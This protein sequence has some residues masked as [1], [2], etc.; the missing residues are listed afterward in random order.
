[1]SIDRFLDYIF[2]EK[3]YSE[4]TRIAYQGNLKD[5]QYHCFETFQTK[6]YRRNRI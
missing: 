5:F 1:M 6:K 2:L 4:H 3:K